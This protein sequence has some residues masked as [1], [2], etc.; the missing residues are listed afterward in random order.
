MGGLQGKPGA[1]VGG[2]RGTGRG[3]KDS[4]AVLRGAVRRAVGC[5]RSGE[6]AVTNACGAAP[7]LCFTH[8]PSCTAPR[9]PLLAPAAGGG[10]RGA[11]APAAVPVRGCQGGPQQL[12]QE[13]DRGPGGGTLAEELCMC[14]CVGGG[15]GGGGQ[16]PRPAPGKCCTLPLPGP[17]PPRPAPARASFFVSLPGCTKRQPTCGLLYCCLSPDGCAGPKPPGRC[18]PHSSIIPHRRHT[19]ARPLP[20]CAYC[21]AGCVPHAPAQ[22][23]RLGHPLYQ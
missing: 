4:L 15:R 3:G 13:P 10:R 2:P 23:S 9:P 21:V 16:A 5:K 1:G 17:A 8:P 22:H 19:C 7:W 14:V 18:A 6:E 12:Q 20:A 11:A